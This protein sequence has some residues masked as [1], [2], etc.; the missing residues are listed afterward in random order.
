MR[1]LSVTDAV[2]GDTR[3]YVRADSEIVVTAVEESGTQIAVRI[4]DKDALHLISTLQVMVGAH[5]AMGREATQKCSLCIRPAT[6]A[7]TDGVG[8]SYGCTP[9]AD[10]VSRVYDPAQVVRV[11]LV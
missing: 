8:M 5:A 2:F 9:H 4:S 6:A 7:F 10:A 11:G 1:E 3:L